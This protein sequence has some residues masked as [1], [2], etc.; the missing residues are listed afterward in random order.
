M[1]IIV[2][3]VNTQ[4]QCE[5][6]VQSCFYSPKGE[7]SYGPTRAASVEGSDYFA[8]ANDTVAC[9]PML[10]TV[11][12]INNIDAIL[13]VPGVEAV[14]VG[15]ADLA[16]SM[17]LTPGADEPE[18]LDTLDSIVASCDK[19]GAIPGI[20][21]TPS[22]AQDRITRGFRMMSVVADLPAFRAAVE[23]SISK[24]RGETTTTS[25]ALY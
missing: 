19:H 12:A 8:L 15:P 25:A 14:Y 16:I 22:T 2:P 4:E 5:A 24:A 9:I 21:T 6:A 7:R 20:H 23:A 17:G 11:E 13:S 3:M 1:A 18:L 10:E